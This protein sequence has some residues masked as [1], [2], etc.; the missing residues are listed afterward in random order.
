MSCGVRGVVDELGESN[1]VHAVKEIG[2]VDVIV[3]IEMEVEVAGE[4]V[5]VEVYGEWA[6]KSAMKLQ[7]AGCG[8]GGR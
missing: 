4:N 8:P 5:V 2:G 1:V 3:V 7:K 6:M